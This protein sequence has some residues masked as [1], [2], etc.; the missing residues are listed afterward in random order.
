MEIAI[1]ENDKKIATQIGSFTPEEIAI[2]KNTVAKGTTDL[3]LAFF[4]NVAKVYELN[5]FTKEI[6]C[7]KDKAGNLL[8]FAGRDGF[9]SKAQKCKDYA[10][11]QS[12]EVC[13]NDEFEINIPE[14]KVTHK[15]T[16]F[17]RGII[18]GAYAIA[19]RKGCQPVIEIVDFKNYDKGYNAWKSHPSD[20]IKKVAEVHALKKAFG[21]S[22]IQSDEDFEVIDGKVYPVSA[23]VDNWKIDACISMLDYSALDPEHREK[24]RNELEQ[25][26]TQS[27][28]DEIYTLIKFQMPEPIEVGHNY[29]QTD[30]QHKLDDVMNDERK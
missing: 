14:G 5:P 11:L 12:C 30:I 20:M 10:G 26:I 9:L 2:I 24:L 13:E 28:L 19:H 3:E 16:S 25:K 7:Y 1:K 8:V 29:N 17:E 18:K 22:G 21:I 15:I 6:W 23:E 4:L 27:R